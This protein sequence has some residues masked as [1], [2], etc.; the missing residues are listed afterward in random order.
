MTTYLLD[1]N[2][3][4]RVVQ[5]GSIQHP[6]A[7]NAIATLLEQGDE[8]YITAQNV[9]E[10]WSV[11]SRPATANGLGWSTGAVGLEIDR[12]LAQFP[13]L[14]ETP[15]VFMHW[16]RLVS[17]YNVVGRRVHDVRLVAVMVTH[18]ISHLLTFNTDD[19]SAFS[20]IVTVES[21]HVT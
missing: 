9:I 5:S 12:M 18:G 21:N 15:T 4:L 6:I 20:E 10:F 16:L 3:W 2:V 8:L 11:A 19:F 13:L 7:V 14:D 17:A 1:T